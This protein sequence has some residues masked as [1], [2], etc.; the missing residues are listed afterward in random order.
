MNWR[1]VKGVYGVWVIYD[2]GSDDYIWRVVW[3][4]PDS[5]TAQHVLLPIFLVGWLMHWLSLR[6]DQVISQ[7]EIKTASSSSL[8]HIHLLLVDPN[9][10]PV[11]VVENPGDERVREL[12]SQGSRSYLVPIR[13]PP[14]GEPY[15][16]L[17]LP[18]S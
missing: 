11:V 16:S 17:L 14:K 18:I 4:L 9:P 3:I 13:R 12:P 7:N 6:Y 1:F 15:L 10:V 5:Y 8:A 2:L